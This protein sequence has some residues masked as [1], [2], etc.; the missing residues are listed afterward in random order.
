MGYI[1]TLSLQYHLACDGI[2]SYVSNAS[3]MLL[4]KEAWAPGG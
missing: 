3:A 4:G 2:L 1:S